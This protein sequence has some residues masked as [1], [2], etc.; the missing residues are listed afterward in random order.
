MQGLEGVSASFSPIQVDFL[1]IVLAHFFCCPPPNRDSLPAETS[2]N[3]MEA[4]ANL[5]MTDIR[6]ST[7]SLDLAAL[8][9]AVDI[10]WLHPGRRRELR[11]LIRKRGW[12]RA[13]EVAAFDV[14]CRALNL[15]PAPPCVA[16][17]RGGS[18]ASRL[19]RRMLRRGIS[20][21]HPSP[22]RAIEEAGAPE[23]V[24]AEPMIEVMIG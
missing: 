16:R 17:V 3:P 20:R 23:E 22:L 4:A 8:A 10:V 6:M 2:P 14:Q 1:P 5:S 9:E 18:R 7:E 21:Y 15:P 19:L 13:A 12:R 24:P 11:S